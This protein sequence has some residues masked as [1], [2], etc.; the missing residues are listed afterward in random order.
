MKPYLL[1]LALLPGCTKSGGGP[2][3]VPS[4]LPADYA[5]TFTQ[6]RPCLP[7]IEHGP[8]N[9]TVWASADAVP[10]YQTLTGDYP[11]GAFF[12][13]AEYLSSD[14]Q[15]AGDIRKWT[16]GQKLATD[17]SPDTLDW[18]WQEIDAQGHVTLDD[19]QTC[20]TCHTDCVPG[21]NEG[22]YKY[23]CSAP[24]GNPKR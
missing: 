21:G 6:V 10:V 4:I 20:I 17:S 3:E 15:C 9:V 2:A 13:K 5:T 19:D 24:G 23:T 7:S 14:Q 16:L 11:E 22:G 18:H 12:V 1:A 8:F